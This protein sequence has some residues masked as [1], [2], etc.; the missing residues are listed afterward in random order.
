MRN[1][2]KNRRG[3]P[4]DIEQPLLQ[5]DILH[6]RETDIKSASERDED[7]VR[8]FRHASVSQANSEAYDSG[9]E[10]RLSICRN[11]LA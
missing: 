11:S 7:E 6:V 10:T 4:R 5:D 9:Y 2:S 8:G 3:D 1:S